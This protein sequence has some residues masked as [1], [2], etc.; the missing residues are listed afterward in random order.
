MRSICLKSI[1][2]FSEELLEHKIGEDEEVSLKN[3]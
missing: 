3:Y 1:N 2:E